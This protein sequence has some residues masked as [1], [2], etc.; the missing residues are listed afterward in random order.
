MQTQTNGT[1][2]FHH[3]SFP[4]NFAARTWYRIVGHLDEG[5]RPLIVLH[6]GPGYTHG[7]LRPTFDLLAAKTSA[8]V[9][10]YDQIGNGS[11]TH[12]R[13]KRLDET[14]WTAQLFVDELDNLLSTLRLDGDFDLYGHSWGAMLAVKYVSQR[15]PP[16]LNRL[17]LG[18]GP[19]SMALWKQSALSFVADLPPLMQQK[20]AQ[21]SDSAD[22]EDLEYNEAL[23]ALAVKNTLMEPPFPPEL[24][25]SL[26]WLEKDDTVVLTTNG[27]SDLSW[28]G[29]LLSLD[30]SLDCR[31]INVPVLIL[32]GDKDGAT[33]AA[34]APLA[35]GI[36]DAQWTIIHKGSHM[37]H[38]E[39]PEVYVDYISDFLYQ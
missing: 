25:E 19:A 5:S 10:Y 29:S 12:L 4:D 18:S 21:Q 14:F 20:L 39:Q 2:A 27:P 23:R 8:P 11:S 3:N 17:V 9:V 36:P 37:V 33:K 16:G 24:Q 30:L 38:L 35:E 22:G 15:Q 6:G 28:S 1:V 32:S 31:H 13:E 26:D 34:I 7:Y